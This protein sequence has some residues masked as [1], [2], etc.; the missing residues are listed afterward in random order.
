[1][2]VVLG[3]ALQCGCRTESRRPATTQPAPQRIISISPNATEMIAE[4]GQVR[5]LVAV[6]SFCVR[7]PEVKNLPRIGGLFDANAETIVKLQPDLIILRGSNK[8]VEQAS[9]VGG[10][11]LFRDRTERFDDIYKTLDELAALLDCADQAVAVRRNMEHRLK[12]IEKAVAGRPRPRVLMTL[13]RRPDALGEVMT[14]NKATFIHEIIV[15]AGGENAFADMSLD[16]PRIGPEAVLAARPEVII[17]AMPETPPSP[18]L[19]SSLREQWRKL[20]PIPAVQNNRV[21]VMTDENC[22]IP[23]PRIVD[24]IAKFARMLHPE[25]TL[26]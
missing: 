12:Q 20:G 22:L 13:A 16:Y 11:R 9:S 8:A 3:I 24:I 23:S 2:A 25:A 14:G 10:I 19:E 17:E 7:P 5:R 18:T 6:C 26:D 21:Y 1:M 4:L 15:R